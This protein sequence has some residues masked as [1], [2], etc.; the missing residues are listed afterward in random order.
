MREFRV[1]QLTPPGTEAPIIIGTGITL[2]AAPGSAQGEV[3]PGEWTSEI[4]GLRCLEG[5]HGGTTSAF[6]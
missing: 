6:V 4:A 3:P 2:V 5:C 1:V